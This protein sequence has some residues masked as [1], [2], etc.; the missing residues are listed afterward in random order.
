MTKKIFT[1]FSFRKKR[2]LFC[3]LPQRPR[4]SAPR[5]DRKKAFFHGEEKFSSRS[6]YSRGAMPFRPELPLTGWFPET[7]PP[8]EMPFRHGK[9]TLRRTMHGYSV[10]MV[11]VF[12][13]VGNTGRRA[14][15]RH[16][17]SHE[18]TSPV[19]RVA[20][21]RI[22][23]S[24]IRPDARHDARTPRRNKDAQSSAPPHSSPVLSR[25]RPPVTK[26]R[27]PRAVMALFTDCFMN[28]VGSALARRHVPRGRVAA[29]L[30]FPPPE[31][32]P[33]S[34]TPRARGR[35]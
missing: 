29:R 20:R 30:P 24:H 25:K 33:L 17:E 13:A 18:E 32:V 19:F 16:G 28:D 22:R 21:R 8:P 1:V 6:G 27:P 15:A 23:Q 4:F 26:A 3:N 34:G 5:L 9:K 14:Q 7:G 31:G 11:L 2:R 12:S 35:L 10:F